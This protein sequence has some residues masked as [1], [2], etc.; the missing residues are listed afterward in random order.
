MNKKTTRILFPL[1]VGAVLFFLWKQSQAAQ[2]QQV[3]QQQNYPYL[4]QN[5]GLYL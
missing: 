4:P 2:Q 5:T 3:L 1:A